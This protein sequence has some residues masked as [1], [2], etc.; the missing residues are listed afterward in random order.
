MSQQPQSKSSND[1]NCKS[2]QK[3]IGKLYEE[4]DEIRKNYEK[5]IK[6]LKTK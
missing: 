1:C 4:I 6:V 2:L 5:I 3:Q